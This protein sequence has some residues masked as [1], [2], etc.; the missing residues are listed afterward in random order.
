MT[1]HIAQDFPRWRGFLQDAERCT[2]PISKETLKAM[3]YNGYSAWN[4]AQNLWS[5]VG[6]YLGPKV[7]LKRQLM[8]KRMQGNGFV[9]WRQLFRDYHGGGAMIRLAGQQQLLDFPACN[10]LKHL[11]SH[12]DAW[13]SHMETYGETVDAELAFTMR[14]KTMPADIRKGILRREDLQ[15]LPIPDLVEHIKNQSTWLRSET[16]VQQM[17]KDHEHATPIAALGSQQQ[18]Q[19]QQQQQPVPPPPD[20]PRAD[21]LKSIGLSK[22]VVDKLVAAINQARRRDKKTADKKERDPLVAECP[23]GTCHHCGKKGRNRSNRQGTPECRLYKAILD[24]NNGKRPPEYEGALE[25]F[26]K[27]KKAALGIHAMAPASAVEDHSDTEDS[28]SNEEGNSTN[29]I[30]QK[31]KHTLKPTQQ[32]I[33]IPTPN[34]TATHNRFRHVHV[35][36]CPVLPQFAIKKR[37]DN[38]RDLD[39]ISDVSTS[40]GTNLSDVESI[41]SDTTTMSNHSSK[42]AEASAADTSGSSTSKP[43]KKPPKVLAIATEDDHKRLEQYICSSIDPK[44]GPPSCKSGNVWTMLDSGSVPMVA[45]VKKHCPNARIRKP[46]AQKKSVCCVNASGGSIPNQGEADIVHTDHLG[47]DVRFA[48]QNADVAFPIMSVRW[49][50]RK[51]CTVYFKRH[52]GVIRYPDGKKIHFTCRHGCLFV[53]LNTYKT[54]SLDSSASAHSAPPS[55]VFSRQG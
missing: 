47:T 54:A 10:D 9:F 32:A 44:K 53:L 14:L 7:Y 52:G 16:L 34:T 48:F 6:K 28:G 19:Q 8:S 43:K 17:L 12:L 40:A 37:N 45:D 3:K 31:P 25:K 42:P 27:E 26:L 55:P 15:K 49:L 2:E 46:K 24:K 29:M 20:D 21:A 18:Q 39:T 5:F 1:D 4:F 50:V 41:C 36:C 33:T 22:D 38:T 11:S 30:W 35:P 51:G 23:A 13:L